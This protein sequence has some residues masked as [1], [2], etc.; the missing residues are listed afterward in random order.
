MH[1]STHLSRTMRANHC[2]SILRGSDIRNLAF[3]YS[4]FGA[5][6][7]KFAGIRLNRLPIYLRWMK[8]WIVKSWIVSIVWVAFW[9]IVTLPAPPDGAELAEGWSWEAGVV[10]RRWSGLGSRRF[11]STCILSAIN[12]SSGFVILILF[13]P[14]P[15]RAKL[16]YHRLPLQ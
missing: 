12:R 3:F 5:T 4:S 11:F 15:Q 7:E 9:K 1:W 13:S 6:E 8:S 10:N 2:C 14:L 16:S